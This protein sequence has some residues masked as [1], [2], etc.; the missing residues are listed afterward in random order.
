[1]LTKKSCLLGALTLLLTACHQ[2]LPKQVVAQPQFGTVQSLT[3]Q[4][5][6]KV[7]IYT[8]GQDPYAQH[9]GLATTYTLTV[10][11]KQYLAD[12][13]DADKF[14]KLKVGDKVNLHPSEYILCEGQNDLNPTCY[15]LMHI[16]KS[17]RRINPLQF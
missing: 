15:R 17:D 16:Y 13:E 10:D 5:N 2:Q 6:Q 9:W 8:Q 12:W 14:K 1:M 11:G 7:L 4:D 3:S